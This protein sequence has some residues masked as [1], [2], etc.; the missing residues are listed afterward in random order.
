MNLECLTWSSASLNIGRLRMQQDYIQST[1]RCWINSN[2]IHLTTKDFQL[3]IVLTSWHVNIWCPCMYVCIYIYIYTI[4]YIWA[5]TLQHLH[6]A[7]NPNPKLHLKRCCSRTYFMFADLAGFNV[8][9]VVMYRK[10]KRWPPRRFDETFWVEFIWGMKKPWLFRV[11]RGLFIG[12]IIDLY[13][14][15]R[16]PIKQPV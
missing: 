15:P 12:I 2:S 4:Y 1:T 7:G 9:F 13:K 14:D 5:N 6:V 16:I 3:D 11:Y 8:T 10:I